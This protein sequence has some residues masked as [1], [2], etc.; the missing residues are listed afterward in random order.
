[1][2]RRIR[3]MMMILA[4]VFP[5]LVTS[6][7]RPADAASFAG[8]EFDYSANS[9]NW[10]GLSLRNVTLDGELVI[11]RISLPAMNVFY[12]N[13]AC[14]PYVD[15]LG[16]TLQD[17]PTAQEFTQ[18]GVRWMSIT[19]TD[20]IGSYIITQAFYVSENGDLDAHIFSKGLQ[21]NIDHV[22]VPFWRIDFALG[23]DDDNDAVRAAIGGGQ[24][25]TNEFSL[26]AD[27]AV[28]HDWEVYDTVTGDSVTVQFDDGSFEVAGENLPI[29]DYENNR[30]Y[31]RQYRSNELAW[32][33]PASYDLFGDQG[34][35]ISDLVLWYS[36]FMP[37]SAAEGPNLWHSTGIRMQFGD[38]D[39]PPAG[40][41]G[42]RVVDSNG[43]GVSGV[44]IDLF[45]EDRASYLRSTTTDGNGNY[46]FDVE[47]GCY[48]VTFVAPSGATFNQGGQYLNRDVC[49]EPGE[50]DNSVDAVLTIAGQGA[51]AVE[52][53]V[54]SADGSGLAGVAIDLFSGDQSGNRTGY[55]RSTTTDSAGDYRFDLGSAGCYVVTFVAPSG[56]T[57]VDSGSSWQNTS[58]CVTDGQTLSSVDATVAGSGGASIGDRVTNQAGSGVAGVAI[59]L[60]QANGDGSRGAYLRSTATNS[61]GNY[62]FDVTPGCYVVTFVAPSGQ[63]FTT[64][65]TGYAN[66]YVCL[67]PGQTDNSIDATLA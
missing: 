66:S 33:G 60:F 40:A 43:N 50:T 47:A 3:T 16:G 35:T 57:F 51:A 42:D 26:D 2:R 32:S 10:D 36:G 31:G 55:L 65:G 29:T 53:S 45:S 8:W 24:T 37:H 38:T 11:R 46:R 14:G 27:A 18:N 67:D 12:D 49:I 9:S 64:T 25:F 52:G 15:R 21:C 44:A 62:R 54:N 63:T 34:E 61:N 5:L 39:P 6:Q 19:I 4:L 13:D 41:I 28:N 22:H 1:M 30:V 17:G 56:S 23:G 59:D 58:F 7:A 20:R 48:V